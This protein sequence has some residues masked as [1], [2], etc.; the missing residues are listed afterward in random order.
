MHKGVF[1][2]QASEIVC[3]LVIPILISVAAVAGLG[4][5][6]IL[7]PLLIGLFKFRTKEAIAITSGLVF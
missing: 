5:G 3:Y 6:I 4:G 7:V 2:L 1:P